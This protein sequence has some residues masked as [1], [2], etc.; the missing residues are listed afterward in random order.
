MRLRQAHFVR[1]N[2]VNGGFHEGRSPALPESN[3]RGR[4]PQVP[5]HQWIWGVSP[6]LAESR[7]LLRNHGLYGPWADYDA[8]TVG[9]APTEAA[10]NSR[11]SGGSECGQ[12]SI[13]AGGRRVAPSPTSIHMHVVSSREGNLEKSRPSEC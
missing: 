9:G 1:R 3:H 4:N 5:Q 6:I 7:I 10:D 8:L 11:H 12:C 13:A 2:T